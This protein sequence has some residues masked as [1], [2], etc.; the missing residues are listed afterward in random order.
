MINEKVPN[1]WPSNLPATLETLKPAYTDVGQGK[2]PILFLHGFPFDK[3]TWQHQLEFLQAVQRAIAI[4]IRGFGATQGADATPSITLFA[5]DLI[6]FM[7]AHKIEKAIVCG[8]SM[9]GYIVLNAVDRYPERFEAIILSDTQCVADTHEQKQNRQKAIDDVLENG[10]AGFADAFIEKVFYK[11]T[12]TQQPELVAAVKSIILATEVQSIA[13]GLRAI[14]ERSDMCASLKKIEVPTLI[15][16]GS[17]DQVT[18]PA[19]AEAMHKAIKNSELHFI[20]GAG[21]LSN[22]EKPIEFNRHVLRFIEKITG[23]KK[24]I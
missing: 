13:T 7:D 4:D 1:S 19:Q 23:Q 22:Q 10:T 24:S 8:L 16:C 11:D 17:A 15:I 2:I 3:T 14:A 18:P 12:Y 21:H 20:N 5:D 6:N 9:G